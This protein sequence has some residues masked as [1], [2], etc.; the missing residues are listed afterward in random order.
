MA[1]RFPRGDAGRLCPTGRLWARDEHCV[2]A[3]A[4]RLSRRDTTASL[5]LCAPSIRREDA[6]P[7]R[8]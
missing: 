7:G 4:D 5:P 8:I 3:F 6:K 1:A 2:I